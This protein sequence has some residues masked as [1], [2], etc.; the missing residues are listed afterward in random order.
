MPKFVYNGVDSLNKEATGELS[1]GTRDE[2]LDILKNKKIRVLSIKSSGAGFS[3]K[4]RS[5]VSLADISRF[6]RQLSAMISAGL[7]LVHCMDILGEQT[8]NKALC[9]AATQV[10][11]DIQGGLALAD[12]LG[13]H[14]NIFN[15][16][17][18][19]MVASGEKS[20]TLDIVLSRLA[21]HLEK[22]SSL[23]RKVKS[24]M[25]Y[26]VILAIVAAFSTGILLT[27]VVPKFAKMFVDLGGELPLPTKIVMGVSAFLQNYILLI[28]G[29]LGA[30]IVFITRY[31]KT[32]K[33]AYVIDSIML[34]IP[35]IGDL[36]RKSSISR[37][38]YT[39]ST[40]LDSGISII[41]ALSITAKTAGNKVLEKGI[42][43][44]IEKITGGQSI[45]EP[46]KKTG[47][48]PPMVIQM[49]AVGEKTG[50]LA[51]MLSKVS[52][53]YQEEVDSAVDALTSIIEPVM[54]VLLAVIIGGI[55][56]AM[57][58]PMFNI[59]SVVG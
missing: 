26:P 2:A 41:S 34:N 22:T 51:T 54:I 21:E 55:L 47:L 48:F 31:Y 11:F 50:D 32:E 15:P 8:E 38:S 43:H 4:F 44:T 18:C 30:V 24:A 9:T 20:G 45:A 13:K 28:L 6:T 23:V 35:F 5:T 17:Y 19:N 57:Y 52:K 58:L 27:F 16:L 1:A 59:L 33:G 10:S 14:P 37:F 46:L 36:K 56:I 49:I 25:T 7:P 42:Y 39:L 12:A 53:F 40:L 3:I 29:A